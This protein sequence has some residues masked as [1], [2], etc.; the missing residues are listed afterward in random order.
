MLVRN[1]FFDRGRLRSHRFDLPVIA[2]GNL[3]VGGTGKS[4][5]IEYLIREFQADQNVAVLSRGYGRKTRGYVLAREGTN[6]DQIGDEPYQFF[7]KFPDL[8]VAVD[9]DRVNGISKLL[10]KTDPPEVIL[11]DDAYQH[12]RLKAGLYVLLTSFGQLYSDDLVLPAGN[13]REPSCGASRADLIVVTKC[14]MDL[15]MDQKKAIRKRLKLNAG[16]ELY[17]TGI[18]YMDRAVGAEGTIEIHELSSKK[19]ILVTGI[20]DPTPMVAFARKLNPE[21]IHLEFPDHHRLIPKDR[22]KIKEAWE[23]LDGEDKIILT[24]EKDFVRNFEQTEL[25]VYYLPI[26]T[27]FLEKEEQFKSTINEY[28]RKDKRNS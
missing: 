17:F 18:D 5:M 3:S 9:E 12:R 22:S 2:V 4:P 26:Q 16:Q 21:L 7:C 23:G 24:T 27:V 19:L 13:L 11:L 14:P 15:D 8:S 20:A 10:E 1:F 28:V 6:A 25:P